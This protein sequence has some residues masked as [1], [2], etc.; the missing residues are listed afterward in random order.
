MIKEKQLRF[1]IQTKSSTYLF[2]VTESGHLKH[3]YYGPVLSEKDAENWDV[4]SSV[5]WG[6]ALL[7]RQDDPSSSL[8]TTPLE[9]SG[10]GCGDYRESPIELEDAD[11]VLTTDFRYVSHKI[12]SGEEPRHFLWP[13]AEGAEETLEVCLSDPEIAMDLHLYWSVFG[14]VIC[15]KAV[16]LNKGNDPRYVRKLMSFCVDFSGEYRMMNLHGDWIR[17]AHTETAP[18]GYSRIVNESLTGFSSNQ[19]NPAFAVMTE[20]TT[21]IGR[22]HV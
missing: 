20:Q 6:C 10:S 22:A 3:Y 13:R 5:G 9:W 15:R 7:Y 21:E 1:Q 4:S 8:H 17:E 2:E 16:L 11:R 19:H 14:D 12:Y 18:V